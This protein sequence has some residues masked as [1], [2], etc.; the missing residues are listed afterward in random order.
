MT[1]KN[2]IAWARVFD[3]LRLLEV[4]QR[5]GY[6]KIDASTLK[7]VGRREPRLMAKQDTLESRPEIFRRNDLAILP[8]KNGEYIIFKDTDRQSYYR[9]DTGSD[10]VRAVRHNSD[11]EADRILTL[12]LGS[13]TSEFQAIDYAHLVSILKTFTSEPSLYLTIRGKYRSNSFIVNLPEISEPVDISGVQIE[14]DSGYEGESGIYLIE[15]K[16]GKRADFHIRQLYFPWKDWS[17]RTDKPIVPIFFTFSNGLFYLTKFRFGEEYGELQVLDQ[18]CFSID[19]DPAL[20]IDLRRLLESVPLSEVEL[21]NVPFPQ[22][23]DLDKIIDII[24]SAA[25]E[26]LTKESIAERFEFDERQGDY[27]ANASIYLGFLQRDL[28]SMSTFLV[29]DLGKEL[30]RCRTR[31]CRLN[32]LIRQLIQRPTFR[33]AI[34]LMKERELVVESVGIEEIADLINKFDGRYNPVTCRRRASTVRSWLNWISLNVLIN[35]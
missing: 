12:S 8:V 32:L 3:E 20:T 7:D 11:I 14:V 16:L 19:E 23:N 17:T 29:T 25:D 2:D 27:Y 34:I 13:I 33:T 4:L 5:D 28:E 22:A 10:E 26:P 15:A 6:I 31:R 35:P 1:S 30:Q 24:V 9:F 18:Q 21:D